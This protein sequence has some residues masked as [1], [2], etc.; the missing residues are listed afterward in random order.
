M[1]YHTYL[2]SLSHSIPSSI[3]IVTLADMGCLISLLNVG[4]LKVVLRLL[5]DGEIPLLNHLVP[6]KAPRNILNLLLFLVEVLL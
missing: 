1:A 5:P 6:A 3:R 2:Y 4:T